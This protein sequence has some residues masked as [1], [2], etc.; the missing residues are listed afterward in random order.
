MAEP[1]DIELMQHA[2]GE[3]DLD[4]TRDEIARNKVDAIGEVGE[5]VR[6]HLELATDD[7]PQARF[8]AIWREVDKV[9]TNAVPIPA[10]LDASTARPVAPVGVLRRISRWFDAHR[11]HLIV[12]AVSAGA[13]AA[14]AIVVNPLGGSDRG[15]S[16]TNGPIEVRPAAMRS[17]PAVESLE[18]P[19]G[20]GNVL[21][22]DDEDGH[23]AVIWVTPQ[24]IEGI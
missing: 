16:T 13:V 17:L 9:V 10:A 21:V 15:F 18:T 2:D 11:S 5:L 12:G 14:L 8:D 4:L 23:T 22:M 3:L 19:G 24:D 20:T 6:G 7:V 1:H